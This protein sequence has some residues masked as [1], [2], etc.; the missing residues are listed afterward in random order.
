[1]RQAGY[2]V[3]CDRIVERVSD[4]SCPAGHPAAGIAGRIVLGDGEQT[5]A[6]PRFNVAAFLLPMLWGPVHGQ[7]VGVVFLPLWVFTDSIVRS[8][9]SLGVGGRI[10]AGFAVLATLAMAGWFGKRANGVGWRRVCDRVS[11]AR[12][13]QRQRVWAVV[14]VPV[15]ALLVGSVVYFNVVVL[16]TRGM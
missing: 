8:A 4:G 1:M 12:Y 6:L 5:P 15:A 11:V 14:S 9:S 10:A 13:A 16:P 2:C 7:W 3:H